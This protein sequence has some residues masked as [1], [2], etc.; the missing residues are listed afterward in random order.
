MNI[1]IVAGGRVGLEYDP[2]LV[3]HSLLNGEYDFE[4]GSLGLV[5]KRRK[6]GMR[7][8][9]RPNGALLKEFVM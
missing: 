1:A 9:L 6:P 8:G 2:W 5:R 7:E 3:S 4:P